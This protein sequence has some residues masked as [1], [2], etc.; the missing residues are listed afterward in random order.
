MS[1]N[2]TARILFKSGDANVTNDEI[3]AINDAIA[4][5]ASNNLDTERLLPD[6]ATRYTIVIDSRAP[7]KAANVILS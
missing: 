6:R 1:Q 3:A 7:K 4:T 5:P 2:N